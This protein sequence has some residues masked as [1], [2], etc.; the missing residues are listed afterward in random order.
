M[1]FKLWSSQTDHLK[2]D[3]RRF[4]ARR[5]A[6]LGYEKDWLVQ[7]QNNVTEWD[8]RSWCWQPGLPVFQ[9]YEIMM[10]VQ[11]QVGTHPGP[12]MTFDIART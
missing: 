1:R 7:C 3:T 6:L 9:H 4:L 5:S 11:S 2:I 8:I 12:D 10:N